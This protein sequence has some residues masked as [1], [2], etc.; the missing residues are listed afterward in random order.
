MSN[1][2]AD[3]FG[4]DSVPRI[5]SLMFSR[6]PEAVA[7][8][9][10]H[11]KAYAAVF[12]KWYARHA[13]PRHTTA[14]VPGC[15]V[16]PPCNPEQDWIDAE[17]EVHQR[18]QARVVRIRVR[19]AW[20]DSGVPERVMR[21]LE[22][23]REATAA[24]AAVDTYLKG[25]ATFLVLAGG[26]GT[27]KTTAAADALMRAVKP[28]YGLFVPASRCGQLGLFADDD[29][30]LLDSMKRVTCLVLDD[31]GTEFLSENSVWRGLVDGLLDARY[32]AM[33]RTII[34]TNLDI[35]AF[36]ERYGKRAADRLK[37]DMVLAN[38]GAKSMRKPKGTP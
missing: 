19:A 34:T 15:E 21:T 2:A 1:A 12:G 8:R 29:R 37:H 10:A 17:L 4:F 26:P 6:T 3:P 13:V 7:A 25:E 22:A 9:E 14:C 32:S 20:I 28:D 33:K 30:E 23:K 27:G 35:P 36:G 18:E 31:L 16:C 24:I 38:C 5:G 11:S